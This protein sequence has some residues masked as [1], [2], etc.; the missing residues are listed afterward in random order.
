MLTSE[1]VIISSDFQ[2]SLAWEE[3]IADA[4]ISDSERYEYIVDDV[5]TVC[6]VMDNL[7]KQI[8][9]LFILLNNYPDVQ[10][11]DVT[12]FIAMLMS[13]VDVTCCI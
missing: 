3:K 11:L 8:S 9:S 13:H 7:V 2:P 10:V 6:L 1:I 12:Y 5:M 4:P